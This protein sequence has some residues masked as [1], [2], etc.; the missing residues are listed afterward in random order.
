METRS[1]YTIESYEA[2]DCIYYFDLMSD[3][4]FAVSKDEKVIIRSKD[5]N[6]CI[7]KLKEH[8]C[9]CSRNYNYMYRVQ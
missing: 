5:P 8:G 6:K 1:I 9:M 3:L 7:D 2:R 4:V